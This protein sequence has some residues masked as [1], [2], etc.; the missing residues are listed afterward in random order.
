MSDSVLPSFAASAQGAKETF[1][2]GA[3]PS[4][5]SIICHCLSLQDA[6]ETLQK[7]SYKVLAE[8]CNGLTPAKRDFLAEQLS[9]VAVGTW[10]EESN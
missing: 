8:I 9:D 2:A 10:N 6:E 1:W 5:Y 4:C 3:E 7:K